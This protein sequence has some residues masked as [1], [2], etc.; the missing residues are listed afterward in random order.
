MRGQRSATACRG[1]RSAAE[2]LPNGNFASTEVDKVWGREYRNKA[3]TL[4]EYKPDLLH[5]IFEA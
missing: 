2:H 4:Y 3:A 5:M 1:N